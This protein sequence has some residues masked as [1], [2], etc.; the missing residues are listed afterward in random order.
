LGSAL[1]AMP[2]YLLTKRIKGDI[3]LEY[4]IVQ[5]KVMNILLLI[6]LFQLFIGCKDNGTGPKPEPFKNPRDMT[7]NADTLETGDPNQLQLIPENLL[8]FS[9][10]DAWLCCWA[11]G[12]LGQMWRYDGKDWLVNDIL[13]DVSG[14][15]RDIAGTSSNNLFA[16][17]YIGDNVFIAKYNGGNWTDI[18]PGF[19]TV[20]PSKWLKGDI[21]DMSVDASGNIWACGRN[22]LVMKYENNKWTTDTINLNINDDI[23]YWLKSIDSF[24][25]K[26]YILASTAHKTTFLEKY[27]FL[28]GYMGNYVVLDSMVFDS[29]S[30]I[31]KWGYLQL[32]SSTFNKLYSSGLSGVWAYHDKTWDKILDVRGTINNLYGPAENY[33]IAVGDYKKALY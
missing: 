1:F 6:S 31:I 11:D 14:K 12:P 22:G 26:T 27:Y 2:L 15:P 10:N 18:Y 4:K 19:Y 24:N 5:K 9:P 29:P 3:K 30:V 23:S 8:V 25:G 13:K 32:Y 20:D 21:L 28:S 16:G 7:W 17:G 33:L